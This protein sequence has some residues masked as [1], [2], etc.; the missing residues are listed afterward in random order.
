MP[1]KI[2]TRVVN[3]V[4]VMSCSGAITLGES[5]SLFRNTLRELLQG[6][7]TKVVIELGGVTYIDS[8]GIGELVGAYTSAHS[9]SAKIKLACLPRKIYDLLQITKLITVFEV[10]EDEA[11]CVRSFG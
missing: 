4:A 11:E 5:T 1:V 7:A 3:D 10:H 9:A 8:S 6:G 2:E